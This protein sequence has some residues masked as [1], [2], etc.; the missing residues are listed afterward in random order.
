MDNDDLDLNLSDQD[1]L[2]SISP[3]SSTEMLVEVSVMQLFLYFTL[4]DNVYISPSISTSFDNIS[5]SSTGISFFISIPIHPLPLNPYSSQVKSISI[6]R[7][8]FVLF[9]E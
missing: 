7:M 6:F 2:V 8:F 4:E 5:I 1:V 3:S 9:H